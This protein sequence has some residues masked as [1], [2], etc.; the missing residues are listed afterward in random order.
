M[1]IGRG[2]ASLLLLSWASVGH[3]E[4][5]YE[6]S[7]F[8]PLTSDRRARQVGDLITI[9]VFERSSAATSSDTS[10]SRR[11][12]LQAGMGTSAVNGGRPV[13]GNASVSGEFEGGGTTQRTNRLLAT[14]TVTVREVLA[15]GDLRVAGE[16]NLTVNQEEHKV[17]IEG[18]VRT[19]DVSAENVVLS[20]RVADLRLQYAGDGDLSDRQK[21][22]W[23]RALLDFLGF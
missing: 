12:E 10:T 21:R 23:W 14:L 1:R 4:S 15:N 9:Q 5:L 8:R 19:Q 3:A 11:N 18:R 6:A 2:L 22:A 13:S 16:Q 20:T 17:K 7:T